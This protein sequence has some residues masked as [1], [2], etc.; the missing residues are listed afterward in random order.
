MNISKLFLIFLIINLSFCT[1]P[2]ID[3]ESPPTEKKQVSFWS[4]INANLNYYINYLNPFYYLRKH[5]I[6]NLEEQLKKQKEKIIKN[7]NDDIKL[8]ETDID[9]LE[10]IQNNDTLNTYK[11]NLKTSF[12]I[13]QLDKLTLEEFLKEKENIIKELHKNKENIIK[14]LRKNTEK[15]NIQKSTFETEDLVDEATKKLDKLKK[16]I[17]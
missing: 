3:P 11:N 14:E 15:I 7:F 10:K 8:L 16:R 9:I 13:Y 12:A 17:Q 5:Q 1:Y 2:E 4:N 6:K